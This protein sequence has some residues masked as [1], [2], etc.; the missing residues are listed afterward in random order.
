MRDDL[1]SDRGAGRR[2]EHCMFW[3]EK[4]PKRAT[5]KNYTII[6]RCRR[7][8]PVVEKGYPTSYPDDWCGEFK[9]D[10]EKI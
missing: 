7:N 3:V 5:G 1:W 2:C 6:G 10:E 8:A 4:V 9:M